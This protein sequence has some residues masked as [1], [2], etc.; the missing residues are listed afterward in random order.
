MPR[1]VFDP[2]KPA[3]VV[4]TAILLFGTLYS[5][6]YDTYIDTSDPFTA[7]SPH[8]L[9]STSYFASKSNILNTLFIKKA[10]A[11]TSLA[12]FAMYFTTPSGPRYV[13]NM[14]IKYGVETLCWIL[15]TMWFFG[16]SVGTRLTQITGGECIIR[17]PDGLYVAVDHVYCSRDAPALSPATHPHIFPAALN[18]HDGADWRTKAR[19]MRGHDVSGHVFLLTMSI[20]FLADQSRAL[21]SVPPSRRTTSQNVALSATAVLIGIWMFALYTTGLYFHTP[22]EKLTG[23]REY[24]FK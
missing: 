19:L 15:F 10:W 23:F 9:A 3:L 7:S 12:F 6:V 5:V 2:R 24:F 18:L 13:S 17:T 4:L 1:N 8:P 11:W 14:M 16:P 21:L 22:F 20:L